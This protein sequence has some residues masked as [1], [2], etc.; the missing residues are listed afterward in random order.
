M[1]YYF[2]TRLQNLMETE[3]VFLNP[4][5]TLTSL[6]LQVGTNRTYLSKYINEKLGQTFFDYVNS[7]RLAHATHLLET[8]N[9]TLEVVAERAGFNSLS[10]F[11]RCFMRQYKCSPTI[12]RRDYMRGGKMSSNHPID[13]K[14]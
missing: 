4:R 2:V 14:K 3:Q 9:L 6:A 11:R 5:I 12:Y 1:D 7:K 8:T 13:D 10:T